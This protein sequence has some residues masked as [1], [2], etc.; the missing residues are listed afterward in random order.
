M[1]QPVTPDPKRLE[2][3]GILEEIIGNSNVYFNPP[4]NT[5]MQYPAIR[6]KRSG[7]DNRHADDKI[8]MSIKEYQLIVIYKDPDDDLPDRL[9][10]NFKHIRH[11]RTYKADNLCHDVFRLYY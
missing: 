4:E 7:Y 1:S 6:Y 11:E 8:Y 3:Q 10:K 2:L 9:L 5:K